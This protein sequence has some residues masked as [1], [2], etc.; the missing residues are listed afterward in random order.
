MSLFS[1]LKSEAATVLLW[2]DR[3]WLPRHQLPVPFTEIMDPVTG[4]MRVRMVDVESDRPSPFA[5]SLLFGAET[6]ARAA[7]EPSSV[8]IFSSPGE[9]RECVEIVRRVIDLAEAG[10]PFDRQ[11]VPCL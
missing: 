4:R 3:W 8:E 1:S 9:S 11:A 10:V 6:P 2:G 7:P 5:Q